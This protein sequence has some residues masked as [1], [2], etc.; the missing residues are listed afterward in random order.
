MLIN[1]SIK[2][3][4]GSIFTLFL[5]SVSAMSNAASSAEPWLQKLSSA[6]QT[7]NYQIGFVVLTR[8]KAARPYQWRHAKIGDTEMEHLDLLNG[9]GSEALRVGDVISYFEPNIS[10]YSLHGTS[11]NGP[12]PFALLREP[13]TLL[14]AYDFVL[15]GTSRIL[16][17]P[18]QQ[19]RIV[20]KDRSR[21]N[22]NLWVDQQSGLMLKLDMVDLQGKVLEQI[23]VTSFTVL[24][25]PDEFFSRIDSDNLPPVIAGRFK[26]WVEHQWIPKWLP[27]GMEIVNK[28]IHPLPVTQQLTDYM[29]LSDGL[30]DVSV[31]LQRIEDK[32][33]DR[34]ALVSD[35]SSFLSV[36]FD[37]LAITVVGKIPMKT[38]DAIASSIGAVQAS[39]DVDVN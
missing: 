3:I 7:L 32:K 6:T 27:A 39:D 37:S 36:Q 12:L 22:Y 10:A 33:T 38:A 35:T 26:T 23:Q 1:P 29:M 18:A 16:G 25:S 2:L 28:D 34:I 5:C 21:Y 14:D 31:Y 19:I 24:A 11:I 17:L 8:T 4:L 9:P 15:V 20:S 13:D 30:V